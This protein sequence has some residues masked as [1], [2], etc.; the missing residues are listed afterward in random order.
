MW[1]VNGHN[2]HAVTILQNIQI[3]GL[4][5]EGG[6]LKNEEYDLAQGHC[7][8]RTL[9]FRSTQRYNC[10]PTVGVLFKSL[11][12]KVDN[13]LDLYLKKGNMRISAVTRYIFNK[14]FKVNY[15][16]YSLQVSASSYNS[17]K[18]TN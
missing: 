10:S 12:Q 18:S 4:V 1:R 17:N 13:C 3:I 9:P 11:I 7:L 14:N 16:I 6:L 5:W 8:Q 15:N 2:K